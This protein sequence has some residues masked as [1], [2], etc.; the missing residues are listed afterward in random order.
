VRGKPWEIRHG[1]IEYE[2]GCKNVVG[3]NVVGNIHNV[4]IPVDVQ[5]DTFHSR[6]KVISR[7]KI[8]QERHKGALGHRREI[9][10][11]G[12]GIAE[13]EDEAI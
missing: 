2:G 8:S 4:H 13:D 3:R 12:T 7:A 9:S 10:V 1:A 6:N 11:S 5:N